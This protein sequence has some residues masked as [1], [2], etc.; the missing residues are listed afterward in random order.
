MDSITSGLPNG[1]PLPRVTLGPGAP[2]GMADFIIRAG[3]E[4]VPLTHRHRA[5]I[6]VDFCGA[7]PAGMEVL[8]VELRGHSP[9][10]QRPVADLVADEWQTA[11]CF[12]ISTALHLK[13]ALLTADEQML[14]AIKSA[15]SVAPTLV[16]VVLGGEIGTGKYNVARLIHQASDCRGPLIKVNCGA[17]DSV[18][19][20]VLTNGLAQGS[21]TAVLFLD[22][23][24]ELSDSAQVKLLSLL[25]GEERIPSGER[26]LAAW[27]P[28]RFVAATNRSLVT[29]VEH[30][31]FRPELFWRLNVFTL[32]LPPLRQRRVDI[33][34]LA[35][36]FLRCAN[37]RR[38]FAPDALKLLA[39]YAF[40]GNVLE[41][42]NLTTRL[43]IAPL[44]AHTHI[45]EVADIRRHLVAVNGA[46][47]QIS[48]WRSSREDARRE[49][50]LRT[51]AAAGGSRFEAAR[52]LGI[53]PRALQY[54]ITKAGLSRPRKAHSS[55][56]ELAS[57]NPPNPVV[58]I[59]ELR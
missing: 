36:H 33:A 56:Q 38:V 40:P 14:A 12:V 17:F 4:V 28:L 47:V 25:Q 21:P 24:G 37:P 22:E 31:E 51:L 23:A 20:A 18:D 8:S 59:R 10:R 34:L 35:R 2:E 53:T 50:I 6:Y 52:R 26:P 49:M 3:L 43:A 39:E 44:A 16:P 41:L 57:T 7:R 42:E 58:R 29:M 27:L 46:E 13:P 48:G 1:H 30:G 9:S 54:H 55:A 15:M 45:I 11:A 5:S 19:P 32:A